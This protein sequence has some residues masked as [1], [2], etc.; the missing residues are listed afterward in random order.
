MGSV[1]YGHGFGGHGFGALR[2][3]VREPPQWE[4]GRGSTSASFRR[5]VGR[6]RCERSLREVSRRRVL[7]FRARDEFLL[8]VPQS[9]KARDREPM[10]Q[11]K[12]KRPMAYSM[13]P[14]LPWSIWLMSFSGISKRHKRTENAIR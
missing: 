4:R 8:T 5:A 13:K 12:R 11:R 2:T 6:I 7:I 10:R 14:Q 9:P 1:L 3:W